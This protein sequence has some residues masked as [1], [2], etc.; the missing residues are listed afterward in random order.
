MA[1]PYVLVRLGIVGSTQHEARSRFDGTPLLVAAERQTAG[2]G[3]QGR[4]WEQAARGLSASLAFRPSWPEH[5]FG[6]IPLVAGLAALDAIGSGVA[7]KWPNDI[8]CDGRKCGGI[9][10]ESD[11]EV[12]TVGLGVNLWWPDPIPG[13]GAIL[14][15]DP[16]PEAADWMAEQWAERLLFRLSAGADDWGR[17]EYVD[18]CETI[19]VEISW[20]SGEG[21]AED[22]A[23]DGGLVVSTADG[24]VTLHAGE[25]R[26]IRS[27]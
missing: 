17:D 23:P 25:V 10:S 3:R 6:L 24:S 9:L 5:T 26:E 1:T 7:L 18:V 22:V 16:G 19:G 20:D 15:G 13:G 11:G 4:T 21:V 2:R 27:A 8:V 12:V 14:D